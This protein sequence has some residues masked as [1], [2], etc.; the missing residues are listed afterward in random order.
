MQNSAHR[1][2]IFVSI[3]EQKRKN[4]IHSVSLYTPSKN[5][6]VGNEI[7][8]QRKFEKGIEPLTLGTF[9]IGMVIGYAS[10]TVDMLLGWIIGKI[11]PYFKSR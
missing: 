6:G 4:A 5:C 9:V 7:T 10:S 11:I 1:E 3:I 2:T 8:I